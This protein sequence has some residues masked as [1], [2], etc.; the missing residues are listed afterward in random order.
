MHPIAIVASQQFSWPELYANYRGAC[1]VGVLNDLREAL[2][3]VAR[4]QACT[5]TCAVKRFRERSWKLF[6]VFAETLDGRPRLDMI[7]RLE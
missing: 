4:E 6:E 3:A 2:Q 7:G 5:I 1:V